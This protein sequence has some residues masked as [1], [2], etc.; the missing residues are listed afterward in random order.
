MLN[1]GINNRSPIE[2]EN[3]LSYIFDKTS[4]PYIIAGPCA[5]ENYEMMDKIVK[6]LVSKGIYV[7]RAG[8]FKPRTNPSD[9][10]GLGLE[11]LHVI[12][13]IKKKY[14]VKIVS[15]I[16]DVRYMQ[17]MLEVV[18]ILQVGARNMYNFELLKVLGRVKHPVLLKRGISATINEF[19][20]A[21]QYILQGGNQKLILCERGIRSFDSSTRNLLDLSSIAIIKKE[22]DI[23]VIVDISHSLGRK[24]IAIPVAKAALAV[25]ADGIM[26]EVHN[27]PASALSDANQQMSILEFDHFYN[28]IYF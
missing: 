28:E 3:I 21:A 20:S 6:Y 24:D 8:A 17:R 22:Y 14:K 4:I 18:D 16:V 1:D 10:Q 9:F 26:V 11:G 2:T 25:G 23:P 19:I 13:E 12:G 5:V 27:N 15:E 7:I